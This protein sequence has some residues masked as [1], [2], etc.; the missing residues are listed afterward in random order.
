MVTFQLKLAVVLVLW[1]NNVVDFTVDTLA[2]NDPGNPSD[3]MIVDQLMT[4]DVKLRS[5]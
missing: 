2:E 1:K 4:T 3:C 5:L